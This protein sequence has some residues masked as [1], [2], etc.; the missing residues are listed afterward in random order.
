MS[1][2]DLYDRFKTNPSLR[3]SNKRYRR[4]RNSALYKNP[5]CRKLKTPQRPL[6]EERPWQTLPPLCETTIIDTAPIPICFKCRT[7]F[8]AGLASD[9][10]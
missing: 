1:R 3:H 7:H 5:I 10:V 9:M 2:Y 6:S 4:T 8:L